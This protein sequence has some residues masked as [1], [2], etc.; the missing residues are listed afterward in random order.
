MNAAYPVAVAKTVAPM[1]LI[2]IDGMAPHAKYVMGI[3]KPSMMP[4]NSSA[5]VMLALR[6]AWPVWFPFGSGDQA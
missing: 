4:I 2:T 1:A 5:A 3:P 6:S